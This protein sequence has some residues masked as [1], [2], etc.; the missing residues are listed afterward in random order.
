MKIF[1]F[2]FMNSATRLVILQD[3]TLRFF[4]RVK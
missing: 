1:E 2:G 3:M 4:G